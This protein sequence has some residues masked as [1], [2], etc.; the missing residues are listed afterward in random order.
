MR[1]SHNAL[2][3]RSSEAIAVR[4]KQ[5]IERVQRQLGLA[6]AHR[7]IEASA[8]LHAL[9]EEGAAYEGHS[10]PEMGVLSVDNRH[11]WGGILTTET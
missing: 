6:V 2:G 1:G 7:K 9:R 4:R 10:R 3:E 11:F 5:L 8:E